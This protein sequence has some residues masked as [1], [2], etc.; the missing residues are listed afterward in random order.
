MYRA[1]S[2]AL[3]KSTTLLRCSRFY[4]S[5]AASSTATRVGPKFKS[6]QEIKA[7][8]DKPT[9]SL[10]EFFESSNITDATELPSEA[11]VAKLLKLSGLP[12]E[13]ADIPAIQQRL[14]QQL[15]FLRRLH[16]A[17]LDE[18]EDLNI[19]FSRIM[20]RNT[21]VVDYESLLKMIEVQNSSKF[22]DEEGGKWDPTGQATVKKNGFFVVTKQNTH[23]AQ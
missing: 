5:S 20:P 19:R 7:Y 4:S 21:D 14:G 6:I 9:W 22:P 15:L 13:G 16:D 8:M 17:P 1:A 18:S 12:A 3:F 2:R 11:T 10:N 23:A